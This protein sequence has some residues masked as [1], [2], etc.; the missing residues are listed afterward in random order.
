MIVCCG[1]LPQTEPPGWNCSITCR[2]MAFNLCWRLNVSQNSCDWAY[3]HVLTW[4]QLTLLDDG[5]TWTRHTVKAP[6]PAVTRE[7]FPSTRWHQETPNVFRTWP[8]NLLVWVPIILH[9]HLSMRPNL[10]TFSISGETKCNKLYSS[11][12]MIASGILTCED[13]W[14]KSIFENINSFFNHFWRL[15]NMHTFNSNYLFLQYM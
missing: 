15:I 11:C 8:S 13:H 14:P 5:G 7:I 1:L 10:S 6:G 12:L 9:L 2:C 4:S 3:I